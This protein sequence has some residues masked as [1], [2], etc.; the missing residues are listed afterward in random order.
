YAVKQEIKD[1][2]VVIHHINTKKQV[3]DGFTKALDR[4][5]FNCFVKLLGIVNITKNTP[6]DVQ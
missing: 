6:L 5:A 2:K 1:K 4:Q 3:A